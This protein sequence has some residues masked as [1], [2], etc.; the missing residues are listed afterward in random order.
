MYIFF[1]F[2][3]KLIDFFLFLG[4]KVIFLKDIFELQMPVT[5]SD[6]ILP[7]PIK[8]NF[9]DTTI[10]TKHKLLGKKKAPKKGAF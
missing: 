3:F 10:S 8:P 2:F 9:I 6:D 5:T 4:D 1:N 7:V